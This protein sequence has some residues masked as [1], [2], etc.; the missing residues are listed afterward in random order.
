MN[1]HNESVS[2]IVAP[3]YSLNN[4]GVTLF[5]SGG[6]EISVGDRSCMR[7]SALNVDVRDSYGFDLDET[8]TLTLEVDRESTSSRIAV[9][10]DRVGGPGVLVR[11]LD[12]G[13][14]RF[15]ILEFTLDRARF[16]NRSDHGT[17]MMLTA[18]ADPS[19]QQAQ[20]AG[21]TLCNIEVARNFQ[22]TQKQTGWLDLTLTDENQN[23][24]AARIGL[25]S[26]E[27]ALPIPSTDAVS[28]RKFDDLTRTYLLQT[29]VPWPHENRFVFYVD[30]QYRARV[31]TGRYQLV[32]TKGIEYRILDTV[33]DVRTN[34]VTDASFQLER[35]V[36]MPARGWYSGDVHIHNLRNTRQDSAELLAQASAED[37]HIANI[38][39]MGNVG[40]TYFPQYD[41][42]E[43]GRSQQG[44]HTLVPGQ[45][46]PRTLT[47]GHTIH[48]NIQ[49]PVR[50][51]DDYLNYHR[52][53]E[54]IAQQGGVSGFA[55]AA[56]SLSGT[57]EGMIM[58]AAFGLLDFVEVMQGSSIG[59]GPWFDLLNLGYR[60]GPAAG[61][62]YPYIGHP[63]AERT[64]VET[65]SDYRVDAWF[66]GLE[67]G[68]SFVT[69][70]P[71]VE[72][73]LN[74]QSM[75]SEVRIDNGDTISIEVS[76]SLNPDIGEL[77][78]LDLIKHGE[79]ISAQTLD[80]G[81]ENLTLQFSEAPDESAWYVVRAVGRREGHSDL[82]AAI[83][84]PVYVV[85][86]GQDRVWKREA[87]PEIVGSMIAALEAVKNRTLSEVTDSEAWHSMP[88]WLND[89]SNQLDKARAR[90]EETQQ[91]LSDLEEASL[92]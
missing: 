85:V 33:I 27:G 75:G 61:S 81:G 54:D 53:F 25:Y 9:R 19:I 40:Q 58:Q 15:Q 28:I 86:D 65:G 72:M 46:D 6:E 36:D 30:G 32:V 47:L 3:S 16:A 49:Q 82:I 38:L 90:I 45:E 10:Y 84:A 87:V 74:Q 31:P 77:V 57:A 2:R 48:L 4:F 13:G 62:D 80:R 50:Y 64:Y 34:E 73:T 76:A 26:R 8:V 1:F 20:A 17:D 91:K 44:S 88:V 67:Q 71:I 12:D 51:P 83:T 70:G 42:G 56:G 11:A 7:A 5:T 43:S 41:W 69:N 89:F 18:A 59:T 24:T 78:R 52:V 68:R 35:F 22:T 79:V 23:P 14:P 39:K 60:I 29:S 92:Q 21:I 37:L 63:G 66:D 55:H